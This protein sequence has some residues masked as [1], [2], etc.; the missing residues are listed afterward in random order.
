ME[1]TNYQNV[2]RRNARIHKCIRIASLIMGIGDDQMELLIQS[3]HD[4]QG[5][6]TVTWHAEPTP[7]FKAAFRDAWKECGEPRAN[8]LHLLPHGVSV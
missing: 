2:P 4:N 6:L 8:V 3:V 1:V 5:D 7:R